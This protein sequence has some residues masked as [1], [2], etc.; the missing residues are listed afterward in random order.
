MV[1]IENIWNAVVGVVWKSI[2]AA[3]CIG[4]SDPSAN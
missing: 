1:N 4:L 2:E 3:T